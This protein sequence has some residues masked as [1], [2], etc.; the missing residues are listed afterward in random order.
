M[1]LDT[2]RVTDTKANITAGALGWFAGL[3]GG[4]TAAELSVQLAQVG[5]RLQEGDKWL[6]GV[7]S[8]ADFAGNVL[9][10][11]QD[12]NELEEPTATVIAPGAGAF[13]A[14]G[15]V[16]IMIVAQDA[17]G[18][19]LGRAPTISV[20]IAALTDDIQLS[21][22]AVPGAANYRIFSGDGGAGITGF[23]DVGAV[24]T[25]TYNNPAVLGGAPPF[26]D[27][28]NADVGSASQFDLDEDR[29]SLYTEIG[30]T[31]TGG[32]DYDTSLVF[33]DRDGRI[34]FATGN[35][36]LGLAGTAP[37]PG[38]AELN[39]F[40]TS[41]AERTTQLRDLDKF[42]AEGGQTLVDS[43]QVITI[44]GDGEQGDI[45]IQ[46]NDTLEQLAEK[47]RDTIITSVS[48]GGLG[49]GVDGNTRRVDVGAFPAGVDGNTCVFVDN[50]APAGD[51]V[52]EGTLVIRSTIPDT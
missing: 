48:A 22:D 50:P 49:M 24:T 1:L 44:Y 13:T 3:A 29:F 19:E 39:L 38:T 28:W 18:N 41:V 7:N 30:A 5:D 8:A 11:R 14:T 4:P 15:V 26:P 52:I 17:A 27:H 2:D 45:V 21:W 34:Q 25:Y 37:A 31:L 23:V 46:G 43:G 47:I 51:E 12:M 35:V 33:Y 9:Q 6:F 42:Q 32:A 36:R 16:D 10:F 40:E 20:T